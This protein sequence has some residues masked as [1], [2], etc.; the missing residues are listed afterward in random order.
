[1]NTANYNEKQVAGS[2]YER[3]ETIRIDNPKGGVPSAMTVEK[4]VTTLADGRELV[5][6]N[7]NLYLAFDLNNPKD[8]ALYDGFNEKVIAARQAR[9]EAKAAS[10]EQGGTP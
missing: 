8:V 6:D 5:E 7:G 3:T 4:I 2:S 10:A 1:M 9:D